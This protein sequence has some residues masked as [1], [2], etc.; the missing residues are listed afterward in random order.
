MNCKPFIDSDMNRLKDRVS[1][2]AKTAT[3]LSI[4]NIDYQIGYA[5]ESGK[6]KEYRAMVFY[7]KKV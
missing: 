7:T 2:F 3:D 5:K 1:L 4:M 6:P